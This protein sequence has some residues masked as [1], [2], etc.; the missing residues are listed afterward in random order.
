MLEY[1]IRKIYLL[2]HVYISFDFDLPYDQLSGFLF[3][4]STLMFGKNYENFE[5]IMRNE[6]DSFSGNA[7]TVEI[8]SDTVKITCDLDDEERSPDIISRDD[9]I[10]VMNEWIRENQKLHTGK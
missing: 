9:F 6:S 5:D 1:T 7:Y 8:S 4:D 10:W 3:T 2:D